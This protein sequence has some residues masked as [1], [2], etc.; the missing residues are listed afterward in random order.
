MR[1][2]PLTAEAEAEAEAGALVAV[3]VVR[4]DVPIL[5]VVYSR[6]GVR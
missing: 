3:M 6:A 2:T 1:L 4:P 5:A